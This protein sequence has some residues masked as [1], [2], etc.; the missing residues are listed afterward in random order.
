MRKIVY[1]TI[2]I[3]FILSIIYKARKITHNEQREIVSISAEWAKSGKP[4]DVCK[5]MKST[6]KCKTTVSGVLTDKGMIEAYVS[7]E[8]VKK[9]QTG[10]P[11]TIQRNG[12]EH[13]GFIKYISEKSDLVTGLYTVYLKTNN[14]QGLPRG[15]IMVADIQT[16][17]LTNVLKIN[18]DALMNENGKVFCWIIE[19]NHVKKR[20]INLGMVNDIYVQVISGLAVDEI[21]VAAGGS[22]LAEN[23]KVRIHKMKEKHD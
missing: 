10:N 18:L 22:I 6:I 12:I 14:L 8:T 15:S 2:L 21:V 16:E 1:A 23:D 9:L 17:I 4:V 11:F 20:Y 3:L 5:V 19:K 13:I 7:P